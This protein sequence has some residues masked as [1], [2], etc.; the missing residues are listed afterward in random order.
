VLADSCVISIWRKLRIKGQVIKAIASSYTV[1]VGDE[2]LV[3][4]VRKKVKNDIDI[5]V[6]DNVEVEDCMIE[7]VYPRKNQLIRPYVAN[8][9]TLLIIVAKKPEPDWVLVEKLLLNCHKQDIK[10]IICINKNDLLTE[11]EIIDWSKPFEDEIKTITVSAKDGSGIE[12]LKEL[13]KGQ[14][15]CLAGQSAVG[16]T[17]LLNILLNLSVEVGELSQRIQRGKNT[18]RHIEIYQFG[19]GKIV[20]TCGF[21]ILESID[22]NYDD[23]K[24]YYDKF[25]ELQDQC[26]YQNCS[27]TTEPYCAVKK[28]VDSGQINRQRYERYLILYKELKENWRKKYE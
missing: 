25:V 4:N 17:S 6:G 18:T 3:C 23:L 10:P 20:D 7:T 14:L 2:L 22:I 15:V 8:I 5:Y 12:E 11:K 28:A 27:H 1:L 13:V 19:T 24:Y 9:D 21:S 16:K 26:R